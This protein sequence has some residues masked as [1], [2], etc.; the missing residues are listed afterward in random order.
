MTKEARNPNAQKEGKTKRGA[1]GTP[2]PRR[3]RQPRLLIGPQRRLTTPD[4][5]E[6]SWPELASS[7]R[8]FLP[9]LGVRA[10]V[11]VRITSMNRTKL[12]VG[13]GVLNL[14]CPFLIDPK[15]SDGKSTPLRKTRAPGAVSPK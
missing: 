9:L 10:G 7:R 4:A 8:L 15:V 5:V 2:S 1:P 11:P 13:S 14:R 6:K 3:R 12:C